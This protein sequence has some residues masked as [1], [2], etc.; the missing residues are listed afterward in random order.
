MNEI[1]TAN[2]FPAATPSELLQGAL[3]DSRRR[4]RELVDLGADFAFETDEWGRL[5]LVTPDPALGWPANALIGQPAV[6][7]LA[8]AATGG[9][10]N[11]FRVSARIRHRQ[12]WLKRGDGG[13]ACL[14]FCAAPIRDIDGRITGVRG[15]GVDMTELDGQ[16]AQVAAALRRGEVLDHILARM[17]QEVMAPRMMSAA[18]DAL[19]NALGA[20]GAAVL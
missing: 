8:D 4:W 6:T 9:V 5:V 2:L 14:T 10:F 12:A 18:L 3:I 16:A 11:P 17:G 7:L 1:A 13:I 19:A 15:T 20:E